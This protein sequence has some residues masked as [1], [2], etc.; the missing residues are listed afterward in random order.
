MT[1]YVGYP[2]NE[3]SDFVI[4]LYNRLNKLTRAELTKMKCMSTLINDILLPRLL[5]APKNIFTKTKPK[6]K[7]LNKTPFVINKTLHNSFF[8]RN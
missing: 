8:S 7:I 1:N 5:E 3:F 6:D 2:S 4:F